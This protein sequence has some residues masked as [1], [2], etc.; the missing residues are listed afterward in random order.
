MR[1]SVFRVILILSGPFGLFTLY[2]VLHT[3]GDCVLRWACEPSAGYCKA[4]VSLTKLFKLQVLAAAAAAVCRVFV[5][6]P[7]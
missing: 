1:V 2:T 5:C 3:A 7:E 4:L 6:T